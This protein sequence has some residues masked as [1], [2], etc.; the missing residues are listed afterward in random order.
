MK[1][2]FL[3]ITFFYLCSHAL[4]AQDT[5]SGNFATLEIKSGIH[6]IK[7]VVMV[8]GALVIQPGAKIEIS[9]EPKA[10]PINGFKSVAFSAPRNQ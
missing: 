3:L 5:L 4:M 8:T 6:V 10:K 2:T 1:N 7:E 9:E